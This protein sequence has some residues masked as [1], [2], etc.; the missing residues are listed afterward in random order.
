MV[1]M[2]QFAVQ[3]F[4]VGD[5]IGEETDESEQAEQAKGEP[6]RRDVAERRPGIAAVHDGGALM[7]WAAAIASFAGK[8]HQKQT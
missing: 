5:D 6:G 2:I 8:I 1:F 7:H 3:G 4:I